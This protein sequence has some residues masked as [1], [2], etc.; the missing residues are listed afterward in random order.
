MEFSDYLKEF[1]NNE[2]YNEL[3]NYIA[4]GKSTLLSHSINV[5]YLSYLKAIKKPN[6]YDI[7]SLVRGALLHD[8]YFYDW[9][10]K[11]H[12]RLHG[13]Y[14]PKKA[15]NNAIKYFQVNKKEENI[16]KSHMFPLTLFIIPK[17]IESWLVQRMDKKATFLEMKHKKIN[18]CLF[19]LSNIKKDNQVS[20]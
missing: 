16:I 2:K 4:H 20:D 9:H 12:G 11:G 5:A 13:F 7:K 10:K 19:D 14:H 6:K 3:N 8:L 17:Y 15:Y 18:Y 1:I